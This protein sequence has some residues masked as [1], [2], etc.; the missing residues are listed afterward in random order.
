MLLLA[1]AAVFA[2][3]RASA[4]R[5]FDS[6]DAEV[7]SPQDLEVELGYFN[8]D[9][10]SGETSI[11]TPKL[12][13]NYGVVPDWEL[14]AE[15]QVNEVPQLAVT[16]PG[17]F[18]KGVLR[19]GILQQREGP[20]I[21]LEA[22]LLLPSSVEDERNTGF[23]AIAIVSDKVDPFL[24]HFNLGGGIDRASETPFVLWGVIGEFELGAALRLVAEINGES[25]EHEQ[26]NASVLVGAIW[27]LPASTT[28]LDVGVRRGIS[29]AAD[30]GFT[31]GLTFDVSTPFP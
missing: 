15:F 21:A 18:L 4:Y 27:Q 9:R 13:L 5:P 14:I 7:V 29:N 16:A 30:W 19:E 22:G 6:T 31:I 25:L 17:V 20:S 26:P 11:A 2:P 10:S 8:L 23:E 28:S 1:V 3:S 12:I 24:L